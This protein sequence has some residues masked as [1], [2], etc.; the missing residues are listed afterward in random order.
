MKI[1]STLRPRTY[2]YEYIHLLFFIQYDDDVD[3]SPIYIE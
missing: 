2:I 1:A 3:D